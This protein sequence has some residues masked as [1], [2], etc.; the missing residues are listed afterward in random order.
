MVAGQGRVMINYL[1]VPQT[2]AGNVI[3]LGPVLDEAR[4]RGRLV[5]VAYADALAGAPLAPGP[6]IFADVPRLAGPALV[7]SARLWDRLAEDPAHPRLFNHPVRTL[8][9]FALLRRLKADGINGFDIWRGDERREPMRY[10]LFT[11]GINDRDGP[12][13]GLIQ[14]R[15]QFEAA[16][17]SWIRRGRD[18]EHLLF[19]EFCDTKGGDGLYRRYTAYVVGNRIFHWRMHVDRDWIV[20][21]PRFEDLAPLHDV[22]ALVAE[23][24]AFTAGDAHLAELRRVAAIAQLGVGRIDY[25]IGNGRIAVWEINWAPLVHELPPPVDDPQFDWFMQD[26]LPK[27]RAALD[28]LEEIVPA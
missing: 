15:E 24:R 22:A 10:P 5:P 7:R 11:R 28:A 17:E 3:A 12:Y 27:L 14:N 16:I 1:W 6:V 18:P 20:R 9:R 13:G 21:E 2:I 8:R 23:E 4:Q 19:V 25:A 26:R